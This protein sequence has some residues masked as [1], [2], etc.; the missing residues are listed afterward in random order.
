MT[1]SANT[2]TTE[3][4]IV[5]INAGISGIKILTDAPMAPRS[6]PIFIVLTKNSKPEIIITI[7]LEYLIFITCARPFPVVKPNLAHIS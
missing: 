5:G 2:M 4:I 1:I 3:N 7:L 6:A